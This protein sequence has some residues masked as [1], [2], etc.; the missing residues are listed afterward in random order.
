MI[1]NRFFPFGSF[2]AINLFGIIFVRKGEVLTPMGLR[3]ER[4][5]TL[6]MREMLFVGFYVWYI[7]EWLVR[8]IMVRNA[9]RAYFD[10]SFEREAYA[11]QHNTNYLKERKHYEWWHYMRVRKPQKGQGLS[12]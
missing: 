1:Y 12:K 3:H 6:Q 9:E 10:I 7:V 5:H 4:I 11:N 8:L 2:V